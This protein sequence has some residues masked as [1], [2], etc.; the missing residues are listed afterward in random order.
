MTAS[1]LLLYIAA[2]LLLQMALGVGIAVWRRRALIGDTSSATMTAATSGPAP[3]A[4]AWSGW[5]ELRV[6]RRQFEDAMG[7]QC[8]FHL[9][10]V[11]GS[12]LPPFL[13]G[14]YLTFSL[15]VPDKA[16]GA[17]GGERV[18]TRCYSLS[19]Q[20]DPTGYR[21]T[22]KRMPPPAGRPEWP[23]GASSS[24]F[25][26]RVHEGDVLRV[27]APSGRFFIDPDA[28]VPAVFIAGGI[29]ITP[30]MSMLRWCINAQP[31]RPV[32]LY[33]G[34]RNSADHAFKQALEELARS[35]PLFRLDVVYSSPEATDVQGRDFQHAGHIDVDLLRRSLPH[36][37]HQFYVC[38][39][40]PMMQDLVPALRGWGVHD[41]DIHF[42]SFGPAS[43]QPAGPTTD[44]PLASTSA[45]FEV[46]LHRSGRTL[47]W[48]GQDANLLDFAERHGVQVDSG[49]RSGSCGA[50]E[51]KL[52]AGTVHYAETPDHEIAPG[53]CL[54]CVGRPVA[55]L[56]LE[57]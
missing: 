28:M 9:Q 49:C 51:T 12:P 34:T 39:P 6:V 1:E 48:D 20:P 46:R 44:E 27:K 22:I 23:P 31:A 55:A 13:P 45:S 50:C 54:M 33:Y 36:G 11:D 30:M 57:A 14:Q 10:P 32:H 47:V 17:E 21:I 19:D 24:H 29:G 26:D 42:E 25:H 5:R 38:G 43:V 53:H 40:P 16:D 52:I 35:H 7:S 37:R 18:V 41:E 15:T 3:A 8:S 2:A 56:A 4:G